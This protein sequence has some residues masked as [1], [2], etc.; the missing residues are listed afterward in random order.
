MPS[1]REL[2]PLCG[3]PEWKSRPSTRSVHMAADAVPVK[4]TSI[5]II[6]INIVSK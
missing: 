2:I 3:R 4:M 1:S 6:K 5:F